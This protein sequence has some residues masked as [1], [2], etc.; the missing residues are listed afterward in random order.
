[1]L[2]AQ[3]TF[4]F[5]NRNLICI[6]CYGQVFYCCFVDSGSLWVFSGLIPWWPC[7]L[8][9][10][11]QVFFTH[12]L[13]PE[14]M[15]WMHYL[16]WIHLSRTGAAGA[17]GVAQGGSKCYIFQTHEHAIVTGFI[18][19][20]RSYVEM[21]PP[22][23]SWCPKWLWWHVERDCFTGAFKKLKKTSILTPFYL[24]HWELY[25]NDLPF[26]SFSTRQ[27]TRLDGTDFW[28]DMH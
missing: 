23:S 22:S 25:T 26:P 12:T 2:S 14:C 20:S 15:L 9:K 21:S 3:N 17:S 4:D 5:H 27:H 6:A 10:L 11:M 18:L 7:N 8:R 19:A 16:L 28:V 13:L 24:F 1:M